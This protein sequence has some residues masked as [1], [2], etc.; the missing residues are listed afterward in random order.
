MN[1]RNLIWMIFIS[2]T[3]LA[4]SPDQGGEGA[5]SPG[6]KQSATEERSLTIGLNSWVGFGPFYI[7]KNQGMFEKHGIQVKLRLLEDSAEKHAALASGHIDALATTADDVVVLGAKKI[8]GRVILGVDLSNG[9]DGIV[10]SKE[11]PDLQ[12][13][14]GRKVALQPGFVGHFFLL[15]VLARNGIDTSEV[16]ILPTETSAAGAA[17]VAGKLNAAVTWEPWLSKANER[18]GAHVLT[19]SADYPGIISD[20]LFVR[21]DV[22][23]KRRSAVEALRTAWFEASDY[24]EKHPEEGIGIIANAFKL[25]R[26]EAAKMISGV[27]FFTPDEDRGYRKKD[28]PEILATGVKVWKTAGIIDREYDVKPLV[29]NTF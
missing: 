5:K 3:L 25:D 13:L 27:K 1:P 14:K 2:L 12:H 16:K 15:N 8:A 4:C 20:V 28:L 22:L 6:G 17:F 9:A 19:T 23:A 11:I 18:E 29:D 21:K 26:N 7:A 24:L 10:A